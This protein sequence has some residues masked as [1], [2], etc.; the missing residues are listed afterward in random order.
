MT[1]PIELHAW[2]VR[3]RVGADALV[4]LAATLGAMPAVGRPEAGSE[5]RVQSTVRLAAPAHDMRLWRNNVG[6][7]MDKND[8]P[9]RFGLANDSKA[10]N[11]RL[12]SG[13]LIGWRRVEIRPEHVGRILGQ[14]VSVEC[15][16]SGWR[17]TGD[18]HE[19]A[20][21]RW[22]SLVVADG[23]YARFATGPESLA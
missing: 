4:E 6:V 5:S 1:L 19:Q 18:E 8:R 14:F 15:K 22:A 23:G 2:A 11:G 3:H 9:V 20:Q 10:L 21:A 7:L 12:K 16:E 17:Y 13:D